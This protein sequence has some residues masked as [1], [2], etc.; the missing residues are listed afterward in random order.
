MA[1][2]GDPRTG[3]AWQQLLALC[4]ASYPWTC[5]LC[6]QSIPRID[7]P[8]GHPLEYQADHLITVDA[9]PRLAMRLSNLRPSHGR[10]NRYRSNRPLTPALIAEITA[11]FAPPRRPALAFF[12]VEP[13]EGGRV[14][15]L[16][17][18][19]SEGDP[20]GDFSP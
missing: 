2:A 18:T 5:H 1:T 6:R 15:D 19:S 20:A 11:R 3:R 16:T 10:C 12:D 4:K 17:S 14:D 7:L 13:R 9:E 8:R